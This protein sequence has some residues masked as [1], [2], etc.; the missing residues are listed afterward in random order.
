MKSKRPRVPSPQAVGAAMNRH[1][2]KLD[3]HSMVN[4]HGVVASTAY[5]EI[6]ES[7]V[8]GL[9]NE[10]GNRSKGRQHQR[11]LPGVCLALVI[12]NTG[13]IEVGVRQ[14]DMDAAILTVVPDPRPA[15][16]RLHT[17]RSFGD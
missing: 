10:Q 8:A 2:V 16:D 3:S 1:I 5:D 9:I 17:P 12:G 13:P 14:A 6:L 4:E 11:Q 7:D 15:I